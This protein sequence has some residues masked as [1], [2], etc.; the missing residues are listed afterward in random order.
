MLNTSSRDSSGT[1]HPDC[2]S[3][4]ERSIADSPAAAQKTMKIFDATNNVMG[5]KDDQASGTSDPK[6]L[7]VPHLR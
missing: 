5:F 7:L 4:R 3:H 6:L 2:V 1:P